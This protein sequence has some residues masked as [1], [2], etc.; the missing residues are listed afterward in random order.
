MAALK[1]RLIGKSNGVGLSRD[2]ELLG[3]AL[4]ASGCE[5]TQ[6]PCERRDRKRRRSLLTRLAMRASRWRGAAPRPQYD[7]NVMLEHIWPQFVQQARC[8]VL[9]P[10]PEWTDRRDL[11]MLEVADRVWAKTAM[12]EQ[13]FA[14]RGSRVCRIG[15]DSEDRCQPAVPRLPQFLHLAGRSPLKGTQRLLALWRRHPGWP[16]LTVLQDTPGARAGG[17]PMAANIA[18]QHGFVSDQDL[19]TLQNAHRFHLCLSEAEGWGHY[20]AEAM[21][22]GAVTFTSD[23]PP[24]S[25]LIGA[26]RGVLVRS[27][28]AEQHNLVRVAHFDEAA[29]EAAVA[30]VLLLSTMQLQA[31]GQ[32]ARAWFLVNKR[33]FAMRVQ[34]AVDDLA[35]VERH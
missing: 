16:L 33:G 8:N 32:A 2:L 10:N 14:S 21:S 7:V 27:P 1:V 13:L 15:F 12:A 23:A 29:L 22:V 6:H 24:M 25:E 5:V 35:R 3:G 31:I 30:R 26:E 19:R 9:V 4:S 34:A 18:H 28:L 20:I 17:R 11:A